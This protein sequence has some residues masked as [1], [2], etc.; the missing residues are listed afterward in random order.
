MIAI[1]TNI[2]A[3]FYVDDP[4]DPESASHHCQTLVSFD[5]KRFARRAQRLQLKNLY[6]SEPASRSNKLANSNSS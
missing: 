6:S 1:D 3:R 4:N 5:D 2:L